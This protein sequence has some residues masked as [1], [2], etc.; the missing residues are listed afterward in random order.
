M[1]IRQGDIF[2]ADLPQPRGS[3]PGYRRPH[4]VVQNNLFNKSGL[5]T[6]VA[7]ALT[8]N[9]RNANAPGNVFLKKG[10]GNL[11]KASVVNITQVTTFDKSELT[12][13]IGAL[14]RPKLREVLS[15]LKLLFDEADVH[16][17]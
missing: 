6:V 5:A 8:T 11:S 9:L 17:T 12:E 3:E 7:C 2:W 13:K 4:V 1:V 14:S 15:G 16:E 10:E